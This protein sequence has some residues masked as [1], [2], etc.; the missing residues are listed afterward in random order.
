VILR[1]VNEKGET[2]ERPCGRHLIEGGDR[3]V[4]H[5]PDAWRTN[6][7]LVREEIKKKIEKG[8]L[9][10]QKY[11]FPEIDFSEIV[12]EFKAPAD[13]TGAHFHRD[14]KFE[15]VKLLD[16]VNFHG[17]IFSGMAMFY[18]TKFLGDV[19]FSG[20]TFSGSAIFYSAMFS[21]A[22]RFT[23]A[24]FS[25]EAGFN[26][27]T[28]SGFAF[29]SGTK[30]SGTSIFNGATFSGSTEFNGAM[31][32]KDAAF[33]LTT[34]SGDAN[35]IEAMFSREAFFYRA[36]FSGTAWF[37][38]A[39]F[40]GLTNFNFTRFREIVNFEEVNMDGV[41]FTFKNTLFEREI[42]VDEDKWS[43]N[44]YRLLIED[45]DLNSAI[46]SY[47]ALRLGF[48]NMGHYAVAGELFYR[49]MICRKNN[50][51]FKKDPFE[52]I[53]MR[54][55]YHSCGFGE[56]P[57]FVIAWIFVTIALF[58][59]SYSSIVEPYRCWG[60]LSTAFLLSLDAFTPGKFLAI[61]FGSL[62]DW[63]VQFEN[64]LGWL[65]LYL[66]LLVFTRKMIRS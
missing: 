50:L 56:R 55:F 65:L 28:F 15:G 7:E 8:D 45:S 31:F 2:M 3:C 52:W 64:I 16:N 66:F 48:R 4:F 20:A 43:K 54:L 32:S 5:D 9:N 19:W 60:S 13:F 14:V 27:A 36:T 29:F 41:N 12:K 39:V 18:R 17:V 37:S 53:W 61:K 34:F 1:V 58:T 6:A 62:G 22:A 21:G 57:I 51:S 10:F 11:H 38:R 35:F 30:F 23:G 42:S 44:G 24:T 47:Q 33:A 25:S 26:G 63:L 49:E 46:D 59:V 40:S